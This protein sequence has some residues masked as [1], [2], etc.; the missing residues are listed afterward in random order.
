MYQN[1]FAQSSTTVSGQRLAAIE[2]EMF[3]DS[4]RSFIIIDL[5]MDDVMKI[6]ESCIF[7]Y[8]QQGV[9]YFNNKKL[10]GNLQ[11]K[12]AA[13][14]REYQSHIGG[15]QKVYF[16]ITTDAVTEKDVLDPNSSLRKPV[17][18]LEKQMP[19]LEKMHDAQQAK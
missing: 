2:Q 11:K 16:S 13:R 7:K 18:D 14:I 8:D 3:A 5:I 19:G 10:D 6:G 1:S 17:Y 4:N 12:Y 9:C 15:S